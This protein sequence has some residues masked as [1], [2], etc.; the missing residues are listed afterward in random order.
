VERYD[1]L[2]DQKE[3]GVALDALVAGK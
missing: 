2:F 3:L 1:V